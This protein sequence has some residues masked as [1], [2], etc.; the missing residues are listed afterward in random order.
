MKRVLYLGS[1]LAL[2]LATAGC[3]DQPTEPARTPSITSDTELSAKTARTLPYQLD[4]ALKLPLGPLSDQYLRELASRAIN[5]DDHL[6]PPSTPFVDFLFASLE[7]I[8]P[9]ILGELL[10]LAADALPTVYSLL[11]DTEDTPQYFGYNGEYNHIM[12]KTERDIK[13]FWDIPSADIQ[14]LAMH[15][16][17]LLDVDK[18]TASYQAG[19]TIGGQPIPEALARAFAE[20]VRAKPAS[21][22][23]LYPWRNSRFCSLRKKA[24][25]PRPLT[26]AHLRKLT[27]A[28]SAL[29]SWVR[30]NDR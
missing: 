19:F 29:A 6:C 30:L 2:A 16:T 18:M 21:S 5:P 15:G 8:D 1:C 10:D 14:L 11:I 13:R 23:W 20:I 22:L 27:L 17:V 28:A 3:Q 9:V 4:R 7:P 24:T 25:A 26:P 12:T